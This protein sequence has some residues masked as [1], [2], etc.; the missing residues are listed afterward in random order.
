MYNHAPPGY[1]CPFCAVAAALEADYCYTKTDDV[2]L[3]TDHVTGFIS[4]HWWPRNPGHV[5]L[6]PNA[7]HENIYDLPDELGALLFQASRRVALALKDAYGCEGVST[8]QHNE[9]AGYQDVWH[10]HLHVFPRYVD[11]LLYTR[12][13]ERFKTTPAQRRPY[14]DNL[15]RTL[16]RTQPGA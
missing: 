12:T 2:V 6:I 4:S 13:T 9:P 14:A 10:F 11:D 3:R 15:K 1:R 16:N 5:I 8:R 7:H